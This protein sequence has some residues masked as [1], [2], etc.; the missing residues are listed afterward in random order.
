MKIEKGPKKKKNSSGVL[1]KKKKGGRRPKGSFGI[2]KSKELALA[3]PRNV[4]GTIETK[5]DNLS[6]A[7]ELL[8]NG[9]PAKE[10]AAVMI[11]PSNTSTNK[12]GTGSTSGDPTA[13]IGMMIEE[14][15]KIAQQTTNLSLAFELI[16][17]VWNELPAKDSATTTS[18]TRLFFPGPVGNRQYPGF[19]E[20]KDAKEAA[21]SSYRAA[22]ATVVCSSRQA[23]ELPAKE[24]AAVMIEKVCE[25]NKNIGM[26]IGKAYEANKIARQT[27]NLRLAFEVLANELPAK[28]AA[29]VCDRAT[30]KSKPPRSML[31]DPNYN[32]PKKK[33][34]RQ[35]LSSTTIEYTGK[36]EPNKKYKSE[37]TVHGNITTSKKHIVP[38]EAVLVHDNCL[39]SLTTYETCNFL[40]FFFGEYLESPP[41][42]Q[43]RTRSK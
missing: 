19:K 32:S 43:E 41:G 33:R 30:I 27:T 11:K 35:R 3:A 22:Y 7:F 23:N 31:N 24:A 15:N 25:A 14:A 1:K 20:A 36:Y 17:E 18:S 8:A 2:K 38:K 42:T 4:L 12:E 6:L 5:E 39:A 37:T 29:A 21:L 16:L 13:D 26:M 34:K 40:D 9:L 28:E 10:A